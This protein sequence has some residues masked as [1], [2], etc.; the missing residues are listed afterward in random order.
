MSTKTLREIAQAWKDDKRR[1]VKQST[2]AAYTLILEN[3]ILPA[4]GDGFAPSEASVQDFVL[5]KLGGGLSVKTV[6][7]I[8]VVLKMV[9][10]F[11][12]KNG[13]LTFC[14]W[15][16]RYPTSEVGKGLEVLSVAHNKKVLEFIRQNFTF[17]NLG[18]YISLVAGLR[19]GEVCGLK[20][21][22]IDV[23]DGVITIRR[24]VGRVYFVDGGRRHT[25]LI[26]DTPKTRNSCREIP[27]CGTL[28]SMVKPLKKVVNDDFYVL[29]NDEKPTEPR[30]FRNYY[31]IFMERLGL[32]KLKF[33]GL[34]HSFATRLIESGCDYKTVSV[35]LG[36]ANITTTLNIYVH[37]N[38]EQKK[39]CIARMLKS[40]GK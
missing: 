5:R 9:V 30:T 12:A 20:W 32:P 13:W 31:R 40:L 27:M 26:V 34:R 3:Q 7:D 24:T 2:Y 6:K 28:I 29:T 19:I 4:F 38:M 14:D 39:K 22:D 11:G 18:I 8:M 1:F 10:K 16:V 33:H 23:A 36:H 17:R 15:D 35:L 25:E 37:P 21:S